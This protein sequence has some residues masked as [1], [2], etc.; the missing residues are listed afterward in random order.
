MNRTNAKYSKE[1]SVIPSTLFLSKLKPIPCICLV[2]KCNGF[3]HEWSQRLKVFNQVNLTQNQQ[4][5]R[6]ETCQ[7]Y[8][9]FIIWREIHSALQFT[10]QNIRKF[11]G[12]KERLCRKL[13]YLLSTLILRISHLRR[14]GIFL[15]ID[16]RWGR[17]VW[18]FEYFWTCRGEKEYHQR[19]WKRLG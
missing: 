18:N 3:L 14:L 5:V 1:R 10:E 4:K 16:L 12:L 19:F 6:I 11:E 15:L 9:H 8:L 17:F 2:Y 13:F 7:F